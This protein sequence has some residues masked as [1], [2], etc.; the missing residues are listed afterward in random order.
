MCEVAC[1]LIGDSD[2]DF[3]LGSGQPDLSE[4]LGDVL[5]PALE[6]GIE[7]L[8]VRTA[9]RGIHDERVELSGQIRAT[10]RVAQQLRALE[11]PVVREARAAAALARRKPNFAAGKLQQPDRG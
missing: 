2:L 4:P 5:D 9:T 8:Q 1:I 11:V 3:A 10:V 7:V 6:L